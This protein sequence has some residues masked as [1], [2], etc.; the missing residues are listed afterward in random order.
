MLYLGNMY[1]FLTQKIIFTALKTIF[2]KMFSCCVMYKSVNWKGTTLFFL[3]EPQEVV[4]RLLGAIA[5]R[6]RGVN[7]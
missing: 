1:F 5:S 3:Q 6:D 4:K 7:D 2:K